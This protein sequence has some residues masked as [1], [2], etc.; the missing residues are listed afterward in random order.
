MVT[1]ASMANAFLPP[2]PAQLRINPN[3]AGIQFNTESVLDP[4]ISTTL[5]YS[6]QLITR[7]NPDLTPQTSKSFNAG[8]IWQRSDRLAFD[9]GLRWARAGGENLRE[10]RAGLTWTF[11]SGG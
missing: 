10:L 8:A 9:L 7:G 11:A 3:A 1:R 5:P 2:N 4:A 6:V